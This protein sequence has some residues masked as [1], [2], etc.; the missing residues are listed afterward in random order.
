MNHPA[1][2]RAKITRFIIIV[3]AA[4]LARVNPVSTS[5]K[6]ACMNSTRMPPSISHVTLM[7]TRFFSVW[8]AS[9]LTASPGAVPAGRT[10]SMFVPVLE[11]S[12][13]PSVAIAVPPSMPTRTMDAIA[14]TTRRPLRWLNAAG[15]TPGLRRGRRYMTREGSASAKVATHRSERT[16]ARA[17]PGRERR[18]EQDDRSDAFLSGEHA[19]TAEALPQGVGAGQP[20]SSRREGPGDVEIPAF[21]SSVARHDAH[22]DAEA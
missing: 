21:A 1:T 12:R 9:V 10:F 5:A 6:P 7:E 16:V 11:P 19:H 20:T 18:G 15:A 3:W 22:G 8:P 13:S 14:M 2:P 17:A 4:F